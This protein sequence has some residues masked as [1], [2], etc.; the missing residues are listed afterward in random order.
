MKAMRRKAVIASPLTPIIGNMNDL[1]FYSLIKISPEFGFE[2][3]SG[4]GG[5]GSRRS[6][7]GQKKIE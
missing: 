2:K 7:M 6:L 4:V 1:H 3:K 5:E